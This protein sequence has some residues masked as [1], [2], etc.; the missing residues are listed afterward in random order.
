MK[1]TPGRTRLHAAEAREASCCGIAPVTTL[2]AGLVYEP[3]PYCK[4][5]LPR[6]VGKI[7]RSSEVKSMQL[8]KI[9]GT[10]VDFNQLEHVL[11]DAPTRGPGSWS[12][13]NATTIPWSWMSS[14]CT[15]QSSRKSPRKNCGE[16]STIVSRERTEVQPNAIVFHDADEIRKLHGVG[17][18]LKEQKIVDNRPGKRA[19]TVPCRRTAERR[20]YGWQWNSAC[21]NR[22]GFMS[23]HALV[24]IDGVRR[25]FAKWAPTWPGWARTNSAASP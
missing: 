3:C 24:I 25:R 8:D 11:D 20:P 15:L 4:R 5:D 7:S 14:C 16:N 23:I 12:C 6:L 19:D 18:Q 21:N 22:G 17:T 2:T 13:A 9:K 10:L 1:A